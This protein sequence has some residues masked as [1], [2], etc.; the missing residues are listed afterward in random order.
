MGLRLQDKVAGSGP[1]WQHADAP[2]RHS[3]RAS[4]QST[5]STAQVPGM[6]AAGTALPADAAH[7]ATGQTPWLGAHGAHMHATP[8]AVHVPQRY[9]GASHAH[10]VDNY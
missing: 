1:Q 3:V 2:R 8:E 4:Q 5:E 10:G 9:S 7:S 6:A